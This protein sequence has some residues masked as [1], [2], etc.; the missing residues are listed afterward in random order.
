MSI[1]K[2]PFQ[3]SKKTLTKKEFEKIVNVIVKEMT[4]SQLDAFILVSDTNYSAS[5]T[6]GFYPN[7]AA[8]LAKCISENRELKT[9]IEAVITSKNELDKKRQSEMTEEEWADYKIDEYLRK[10]KAKE[11]GQSLAFIK[12]QLVVIDTDK[13]PMLTF[14]ESV[15]EDGSLNDCVGRRFSKYK[16]FISDKDLK[17]E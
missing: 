13:G 14:A 12:S 11:E 9:L 6:S 1:N 3:G 10:K 7:I 5:V 15:N 8:A 4:E 2:Y 16:I 17:N